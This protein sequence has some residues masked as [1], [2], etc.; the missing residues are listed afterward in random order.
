[1]GRTTNDKYYVSTTTGAKRGRGDAGRRG[2][3]CGPN[4]H[5][6]LQCRLVLTPEFADSFAFLTVLLAHYKI[7]IYIYMYTLNVQAPVMSECDFLD[8]A[9]V[10]KIQSEGYLVMLYSGHDSGPGLRVR[11]V[12]S[13]ICEASFTACALQTNPRAFIETPIA[14][15]FSKVACDKMS[16][17]SELDALV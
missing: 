16:A 8:V 15:C 5:L 9:N 7:Y 10:G 13:N 12:S 6:T 2:Y 4:S 17:S 1:M 3:V 11:N 14:R